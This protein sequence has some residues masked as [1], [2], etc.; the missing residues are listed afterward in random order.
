MPP[1]QEPSQ[2]APFSKAF[3]E[4]ERI[5]HEFERGDLDLELGLAKFKEAL[6]LAEICK[7][8]LDE[9]ENRVIALKKQFADF[10]A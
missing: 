1:K 4:L 5:V 7:K 6:E 3:H 10:N 8:R 9:V 2:S